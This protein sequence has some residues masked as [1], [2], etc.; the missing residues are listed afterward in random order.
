[1]PRELR[2]L[3]HDFYLRCDGCTYD[4]NSRKLH[5]AELE[6]I[7][8]SLMYTCKQIATE[9]HGLPLQKNK[10]FFTTVYPKNLRSNAGKFAA[11]LTR[12]H[13]LKKSLL[14]RSQGFITSEL[15]S[16]IQIQYPNLFPIL[17]RIKTRGS[18]DNLTNETCGFPPSIHYDFVT[19]CLRLL[20]KDP[21]FGPH[22]T[23]TKWNSM[24]PR[25]TD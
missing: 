21:Q 23:S 14:G 17:D 7:D 4:H 18:C 6:K 22:I 16:E 2:D 11:L 1:L 8:L 13:E 20:S 10:V 24:G 9:M 25:N 5:T 12:L 19:E 3:I 15:M